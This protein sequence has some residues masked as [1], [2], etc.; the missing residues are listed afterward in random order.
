MLRLIPTAAHTVEDINETIAAFENPVSDLYV[1]FALGNMGLHNHP[2]KSKL[3]A[4]ILERYPDNRRYV[5]LL[6]AGHEDRFD[7]LEKMS[8]T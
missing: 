4:N 3:I 6:I 7:D 5:R 1:L 8:T 2:G